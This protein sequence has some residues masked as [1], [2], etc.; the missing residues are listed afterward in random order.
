MIIYAVEGGGEREREREIVNHFNGEF[1]LVQVKRYIDAYSASSAVG[2][3]NDDLSRI[4]SV[5]AQAENHW[6]LSTKKLLLDRN[7]GGDALMPALK[8]QIE[9]YFNFLTTV[10]ELARSK[11]TEFDLP[12]MGTGIG[13][14]FISLIFQVLAIIRANRQHDVT[15]SSSEDS[16]FFSASTFAF[17]LLGIRACSFL[18]N[19]YICKCEFFFFF[20]RYIQLLFSRMFIIH[21]HCVFHL[22]FIVSGG[23]ES[24]K[25]SFEHI[26]NC[27]TAPI[28]HLGETASRSMYFTYFS[29]I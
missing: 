3:S 10:A 12:M 11:W 26:W 1:L 18:S 28:S 4:A 21:S 25:F 20:S 22:N 19:S 23:R 9:A 17:F 15:L 16:W 8:R 14:M 24:G 29:F 5:Y 7:N 2:F 27:S 13:I 6:L